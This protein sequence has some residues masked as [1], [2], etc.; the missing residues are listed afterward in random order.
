M[1][2]CN[3]NNF[4]NPDITSE[5]YPYLCNTCGSQ[6][7]NLGSSNIIV[8]TTTQPV[9]TTTTLTSS[10]STSS[11]NILSPS[12]ICYVL[13]CLPGFNN[14]GKICVSPKITTI[15]SLNFLTYPFK[16]IISFIDSL[17]K[18]VLY[19]KLFNITL[20]DNSKNDI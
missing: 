19:N 8:D 10:L 14:L 11:T 13:Y 15:A 17:G 1:S 4:G 9:T 3:L 16:F 7:G 12:I 20:T 2:I 5:A 18:P 6:Y